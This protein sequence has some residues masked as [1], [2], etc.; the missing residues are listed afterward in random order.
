[1]AKRRKK[2]GIIMYI[3]QNTVILHKSFPKHPLTYPLPQKIKKK[4]KDSEIGKSCNL[5]MDVME[6][7]AEDE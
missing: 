4:I 2:N 1:M 6:E 5:V 3:Y 7:P